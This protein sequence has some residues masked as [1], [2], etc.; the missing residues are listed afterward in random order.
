M[1]NLPQPPLSVPEAWVGR[2]L[3]RDPARWTHELSPADQAELVAAAATLRDT[4]LQSITRD[5]AAMPGLAPVLRRLRAQIQTGLGVVLV[6]GFP[7]DALSLDDVRRVYWLVGCH[8]G[9]AV[10]QN[11]A[12]DLMCDIRDTG[13]D[14]TDPD[15]RLYTTSAEQDFHTDGADIIGLLCL[16][17]AQNGGGISRLASSVTVYNEVARQRPDLVHLLFE[18]W[19]W[20]L[21]GQQPSD[22]APTFAFPI[23]RWDGAHLA[24][25]FIGW[26][27]RRAQGVPGVPALTPEQED[28][29]RLYE[30]V[31]NTPGTY[32]DMDFRPGDM[33][34]IRNA[35]VLH[36]RT[37]YTDPPDPAQRRHLLRLWLTARD[38]ADG[39][40]LLRGGLPGAS[41]VTT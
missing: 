19:H 6:R 11:G 16:R 12:G 39:D 24:T 23:T 33:Q 2:D 8:L 38:F 7:T 40:E 28:V 25:F 1:S 18:D 13:A 36:K 10:S 41:A 15:V 31:A 5:S 29:L 14:P 30:Q 26:W 3:E 32:L 20:Y 4:P 37:A 35:V 17:A 27:I 22:V 34:W 21:H 9:E